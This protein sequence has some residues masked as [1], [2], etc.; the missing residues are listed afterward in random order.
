M[1]V[2]LG[3]LLVLASVPAFFLIVGSAGPLITIAL[4]LL[5]LI[6]SEAISSRGPAPTPRPM[7]AIYRV[8]PVIYI[9]LQLATTLWAIGAA[10]RATA[11]GYVSLLLAI[12]VT[13]GVFGVLCAHELV[14]GKNRAGRA[15]GA[16]MLTGMCYRHFRVAHIHGHHRYAGTERDSATARLGEGFYAFLIRTVAG[17]FQEAWHHERART[18]A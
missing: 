16:V 8:L 17:Q 10:S 3:P 5:F 4:L 13:T 9:P 1:F 6:G 11:V 15:W 12:G 18:K 14:H 7:I 2:Y